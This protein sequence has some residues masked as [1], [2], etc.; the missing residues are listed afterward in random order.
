MIPPENPSK[1]RVKDSSLD[2]YFQPHSYILSVGTTHISMIAFNVL[3]VEGSMFTCPYFVRVVMQD[4][5]A[6]LYTIFVRNV[7][8]YS[9]L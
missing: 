2:I 8:L 9:L 5:N 4:W 7:Y 1:I 3:E 6:L